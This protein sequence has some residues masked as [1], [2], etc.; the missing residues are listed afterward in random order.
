MFFFKSCFKSTENDTSLEKQRKQKVTAIR[1]KIQHMDIPDL[2]KYA[3]SMFTNELDKCFLHMATLELHTI[4]LKQSEKVLTLNEK[5][6]MSDAFISSYKK[7]QPQNMEERIDEMEKYKLV[8]QLQCTPVMA[9]LQHNVVRLNLLLK[10]LG[11]KEF[12]LLDVGV[13]TIES[14]TEYQ[15]INNNN[16]NNSM[17]PKR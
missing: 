4:V 12:K 3:D 10:K 9:D 13:P 5:N 8:N 11:E 16:N 6:R 15:A 17:S 14:V 7:T 2:E 1:E